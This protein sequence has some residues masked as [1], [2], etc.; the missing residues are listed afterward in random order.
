MPAF[1]YVTSASLSSLAVRFLQVVRATRTGGNCTIADR[2]QA[3]YQRKLSVSMPIRTCPAC[4]CPK[5]RFLA[6]CSEDALVNYYRCS[7]CGHV[8]ATTKDDTVI[9]RHVTTLTSPARPLAH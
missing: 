9:V 3:A 2:P 8:W 6:E 7:T 4:N 5:P 1:L